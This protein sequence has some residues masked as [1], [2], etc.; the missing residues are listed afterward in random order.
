MEDLSKKKNRTVSD[1]A[2]V[3]RPTE[4]PARGIAQQP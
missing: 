2:K 4:T 1:H 3:L